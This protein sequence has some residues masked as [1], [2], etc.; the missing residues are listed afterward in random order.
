MYA[1]YWG[2]KDVV[3]LLL[4]HSDEKIDFDAQDVNGW[5]AFMQ[6]C[7]GGHT[8]VVQLILE[9]AKAKG[10]EIPRQNYGSSKEIT[11]LLKNY[12]KNNVWNKSNCSTY[13][14]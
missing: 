4:D 13:N 9:Y 10:I 14:V 2:H 11:D 6:A 7:Q 3:K 5:T 12:H 1:C 8:I